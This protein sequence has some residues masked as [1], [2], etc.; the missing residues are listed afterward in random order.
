MPIEFA[1]LVAASL[2]AVGAMRLLPKAYGS[3]TVALFSAVVLTWLSWQS[4][5]WLVVGGA[6]TLGFMVL[7]ERLNLKTAAFVVAV[8]LHV[9]ALVLLRDLPGYAWIGG[10]YF[11]LRHVHVLSD[12]WVGSLSRPRWD[13]YARYHLFLPV[14]AAGPIHRY[15]PFKRQLARRRNDPQELAIGAERLLWGAFQSIV[16]GHFLIAKAQGILSDIIA[17][18]PAFLFQWALSALDWVGLYLTFAGLSSV[19]I[20]LALMMGLRIEEN[21]NA[22]WRAQN[23]VDFWSRWHMTLT[24][25]SRD[26]VFRPVAA[27][28]RSSAFGAFS[29][30]IFLGIWHG[31][32]VYWLG[33]GIWQGLGILLTVQAQR[34]PFVASLPGW[35]GKV[36]A[37]LWL[38]ATYPVVTL[39]TG[40]LGE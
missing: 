24:G 33:W 15:Q 39:V 8:V 1:L 32:T 27:R 6:L 11:T 29:A 26:Y 20:G 2:L 23:L 16:L 22:P 34:L 13:D 12:W 5:V 40:G 18:L 21:F 35:S 4:A 31:S 37:A 9:L 3:A 25:F 28:T 14:L 38:S 19:A 7:G 36:F 10:A 17:P 30:M